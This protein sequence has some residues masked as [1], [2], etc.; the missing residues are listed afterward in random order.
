MDKAIP[1][2]SGRSFFG[3]S[4]LVALAINLVV[5]GYFGYALYAPA[6]TLKT[7]LLPGTTTHGHYQIELDCD[8]CH[9]P[10]T[11]DSDH[12]SDNVMQDACNR[13][14]ADQLRLANDTHPAKKFNDPTNADLLQTLDAQNCL[15][16][17]REHVPD[18]TLASGLTVPADYCWHCHQDVADKRPSHV[19]MKFDSCATAACHNYHDN[20]ALYEKFLSEHFGEPD[21]F[22]EPTQ[23]LRNFA[24]QWAEA[25]RRPKASRPDAARPSDDASQ[26]DAIADRFVALGLADIDAPPE[27]QG[28]EQLRD[29]WASTAHAASGV[30]CRGCHDSAGLDSGESL[31]VDQVSMDACGKCHERQAE[32][33]VQGRHGMRLAVGMSPLNPSMARLPMHVDAV[34]QELTCNTC[35][36]D[37]EFDTQFAAV[38]ACLNCHADSHSMAYQSSSHAEA[39]AGEL[40]G[41]LPPGSGVTCATCHLPRM[42]DGTDVWV[43]HDQNANLRPRETMAREVC[44]HCHG[45]E[46]SL[47]SLS[48]PG[49]AATCFDRPPA[50]R[51]ESVNMAHEYFAERE[52]ARK[53]RTKSNK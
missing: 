50:Q 53:R 47:S 36:K 19:G 33:F 28:S 32:S 49:S 1:N 17:H 31:W 44:M 12:S 51:T 2:D 5:L 39:W 21:Y 9:Q 23:P 15:T 4:W 45:L 41:D 27:S 30:S 34:H 22:D 46:F 37:H 29:Q 42:T 43:N 13:C 11:N 25:T 48:D 24:A 7:T 38:D 6:S 52:R 3:R 20:R 16:C 14:H 35:H 40:A 18:Q 26:E 10:T 8:A